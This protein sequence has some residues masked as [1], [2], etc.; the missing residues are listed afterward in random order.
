MNSS[1]AL[2]EIKV[3]SINVDRNYAQLTDGRGFPIKLKF[4]GPFDEDHPNVKKRNEI[5]TNLRV[6]LMEG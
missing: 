2:S 5:S 3:K 6:N 1:A 4:V